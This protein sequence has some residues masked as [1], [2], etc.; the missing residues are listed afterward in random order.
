MSFQPEAVLAIAEFSRRLPRKVNL[1]CDRTLE[2]GR[3]AGTTVLRTEHVR[4]AH[5]AILG[6]ETTAA[7]PGESKKTTDAAHAGA[8]RPL[9]FGMTQH[10]PRSRVG[11]V[12]IGLVLLLALAA[13]GTY[14]YVGT[15]LV[16]ESPGFPPV[17]VAPVFKV[18][19]LELPPMPTDDQMMGKD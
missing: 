6:A 11:A 19:T 5:K 8:E 10:A 1:L 17:P 2:E 18:P 9:T 7:E 16:Y 13:S 15:R 12:V 14:A 4:R 3:V